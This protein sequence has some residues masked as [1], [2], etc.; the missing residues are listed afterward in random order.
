MTTFLWTC[1]FCGRPT[2]IT[3]ENYQADTFELYIPNKYGHMTIQNRFITCPNPECR[4]VTFSVLLYAMEYNKTLGRWKT[5]KLKK[6]WNLIPQSQ[7]KVFPGYIPEAIRADYSEACAIKDLSSKASATISRRCLQGM[8]RDFWGVKKPK[9]INEIEAIKDRV[10][11]LTWQA[12]DSVREVGNIGAHME[13]DINLIIDVEPEEASLLINLIETLM[14]EWYINRHERQ[15]QL[16][17]IVA[18]KEQKL[19]QKDSA[20]DAQAT[21]STNK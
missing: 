6:Q 15:K 2:T 9:L 12:I 11:P 8:I 19:E 14:K 17:E 10:D 3:D 16:Q 4:E 7:A 5:A 18:M 13:K 21:N 1:P 20:T